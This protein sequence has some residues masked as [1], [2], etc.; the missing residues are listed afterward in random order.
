MT[1][2]TNNPEITLTAGEALSAH[3]LVIAAGTQTT[4][5]KVADKVVGVTQEAVA[6]AL[7]AR[8]RL[9]AA[10]TCKITA[11]GAIASGQRCYS[12]TLGKI[13][14]SNQGVYV[15][16]AAEA[17]TADGDII[18]VRG[19]AKEQSLLYN[20]LAASAAVTNTSAETAFDKSV[21]LPVNEL[22]PG[23]EIEFFAQ[24]IATATNATDTLNIK[25]L[26]GSTVLMATGAVDVANNDIFRIHGRLKV[27]T[28]GASGTLV[29]EGEVAIGAAGT[30]TMKAQFLAST[31]I[32]TTAT[33]AITVSATWSVA[34]AG[35]SCRLDELTVR[36]VAD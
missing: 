8:V 9:L 23:D 25:L 6:N 2:Q 24:G 36:R 17:A 35:N 7:M 16:R 19:T 31:A 3:R 21:T 1:T 32:D 22:Q 4:G 33:Q 27:R 11:G 28:D 26:I 13:S 18:E 14:K 34:N 15:G 5:S 12:A 20:N 10:G 29:A 30:V